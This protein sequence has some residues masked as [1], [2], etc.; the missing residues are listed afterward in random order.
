MFNIKSLLIF[1]ALAFFTFSCE[2][3][4]LVTPADNDSSVSE[5]SFSQT[6]DIGEMP[7][8]K[9]ILI[10]NETI[11]AAI[12]DDD[13]KDENAKSSQSASFVYTLSNASSG[14]EVIA[15]SS[16][17]GNLQEIGRFAT[18]GTGTD[19]NLANQGALILNRNQNLLFATDAGSNTLAMFRVRNN[20]TLRLVDQVE[21]R[22]E[23]P[24][25]VTTFANFVYV[26]NNGSDD[27]EGYRISG[28]ASLEFIQGSQ[29]SLSTIGT[30]PAQISFGRFGRVL[31]VTEKATNKITTFTINSNASVDP[32]NSFDSA[33][34]TPFGFSDAF[35]NII[36]VS[37]ATGGR[38]GEGAVVTYRVDRFSGEVTQSS[39][40]VDDFDGSATCWVVPTNNRRN[41]FVTNTLS[42]DI[43]RLRLG[44]GRSGATTLTTDPVGANGATN[45]ATPA[46]PHDLGLNRSNNQLFVLTVG[47][48]ELVSYQLD[49]GNDQLIQDSQLA[50]G[51][52]FA[53][54]IAV[55]N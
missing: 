7:F 42:D 53:T 12:G 31:I 45:V 55:K 17:P 4:D 20:G 3:D 14:N 54:G 47:S 19:T 23:E 28:N 51:T 10:S 30:A 5:T 16:T 43:T 44:L 32:G 26:V 37:H 6:D 48:D 8:D 11:M 41:Y 52:I 29:Q 13:F 2:K 22:G 24:I 9:N 40:V 21:L 49:N 33:A 38:T 34:D 1:S 25:S 39:T 15:Y 46:T 27:I 36:V 18:G 35:S 50:T